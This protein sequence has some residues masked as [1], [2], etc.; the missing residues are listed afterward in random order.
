MEIGPVAKLVL[1]STIA[2]ALAWNDQGHMMVAATAYDPLTPKTK[3]R[4]G[5][6][7]ALNRHPTKRANDAGPT[8]KVKA[9]FIGG[10]SF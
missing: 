3:T 9:A 2:P 10:G 1:M 7:L 5:L 6:F 8:D 4:V